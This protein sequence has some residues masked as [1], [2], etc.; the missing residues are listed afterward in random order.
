MLDYLKAGGGGPG[1]YYP[2]LYLQF[3]LILPFFG[4][5]MKDKG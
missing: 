3:A 5:L 4:R 1:S 2:W